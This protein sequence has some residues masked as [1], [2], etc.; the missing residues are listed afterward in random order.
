VT[1]RGD[2][3][4]TAALSR[5][6]AAEAHTQQGFTIRVVEGPDTGLSASLDAAVRKLLVGSSPACHLRLT[7][8][9]VSRRHTALEL[10]GEGLRLTDL[11]S[12]NGTSVRGLAVREC[13]V[14]LGDELRLGE[15]ALRVE[16]SQA[17]SSALPLVGEFGRVV[18]AS[19][20][21]RALYPMLQRLAATGI[22]VLIEGE[23]GTGKEVVAESLHEQGARAQGPFVVFDCTTVSSSLM[24]AALFGHEKGA[25]TGAVAAR[26]GVFEQAHG[27]TLFI[28]EIGDLE[29]ALQSKLLR[30]IERAEV[31][32]VGSEKWQTF[33]V[34]IVAATRRDLDKE[35]QGGRFRD[36]LFFRLAV[37]RVELP[38]LRRRVGDIG[39]LARHFWKKLGGDSAAFPYAAL[40]KLEGYG[41]PGNVREL[42]NAMMRLI[43]L[44]DM[45]AVAPAQSASSAVGGDLFQQMLDS[46]LPLPRARA[47]LVEEFDRCFVERVL[48]Q[49]GGDVSAAA[50]ASG[51]GLRYFYQLKSRYGK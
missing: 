2:D 14:T 29:P 41:W 51:I 3:Q 39:L 12:T 32:R 50:R 28:D 9:T 13:V 49:H 46:G 5:P 43:A 10:E 30:A 8:R 17:P 45:P 19:P 20:E 22:P 37:A 44:G 16:R 36:D 40:G 33:D 7:D 25:F 48:A 26:R 42:S 23:T 4:V 31:Q 35:V 47:Q 21:M 15:T 6:G 38:A 34:R 11:G 27:G 18:G 1:E 24:E